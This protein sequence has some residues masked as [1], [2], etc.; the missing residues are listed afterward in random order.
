VPEQVAVLGCG[1]D[2]VVV[3][4]TRVPLSSVDPDIAGR[5]Y[6]AAQLLDRMMDGG[7]PPLET[8]LIEPPGIVTRQSSDILAVPDLRVAAA[9]TLI[10][11]SFTDVSLNPDVISEACGVPP[12][13]LARLF[14]QHLRRTVADEIG[15][16][17]RQRAQQLL[18]TT[19][20]SASEIAD[21]AG[22][23]GLLHMRRQLQRHTQL[24]PRQWRLERGKD[25][26]PGG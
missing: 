19:A 12:R 5:A 1:N 7:T 22:F 4:F 18:V 25:A 23:A 24:T 20:L 15:R 8:I 26:A 9:L 21:Q 6:R 11:R 13:T 3:D 10:R 14:K 17:R 2:P 16:L